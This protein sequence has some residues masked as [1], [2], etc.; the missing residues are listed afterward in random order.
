[1]SNDKKVSEDE[2]GDQ[3]RRL[4]ATI[5]AQIH[6]FVASSIR[7]DPTTTDVRLVLPTGKPYT[8]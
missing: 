7:I 2:R 3:Q 5:R 8:G 4:G 1:M 6:A